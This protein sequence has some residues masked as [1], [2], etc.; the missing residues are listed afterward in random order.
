MRDSGWMVFVE[1]DIVKHGKYDRLLAYLWTKQNGL[2]NERMVR[3]RYA[4]LFTISPNAIDADRLAQAEHRAR[5]D[6][7]GMGDRRD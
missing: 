5:N 1:T 3:E 7:K 6:R 4:V 2:I